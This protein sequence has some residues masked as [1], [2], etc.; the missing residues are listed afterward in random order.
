MPFHLNL[1]QSPI[2]AI[3]V[4][5]IVIAISAIIANRPPGPR[6]HRTRNR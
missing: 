6:K 3:V 1:E 5:V 4:F 2:P